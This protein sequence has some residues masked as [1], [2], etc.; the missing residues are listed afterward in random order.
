MNF[1]ST[2]DLNY[3]ELFFELVCLGLLFSCKGV[4]EIVVAL[5]SE[6][7]VHLGEELFYYNRTKVHE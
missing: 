3:V 1:K 7:N 5:A 2:I 6:R 4:K